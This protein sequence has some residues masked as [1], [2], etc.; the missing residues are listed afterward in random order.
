MRR[1]LED[2]H[3]EKS[4]IDISKKLL[5]SVQKLELLIPLEEHIEI[6]DLRINENKIKEEK[7]ETSI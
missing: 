2:L 5:E 7:S 6:L 3:K 1:C 4:T